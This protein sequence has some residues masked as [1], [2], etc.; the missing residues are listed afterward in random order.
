MRAI[1]GAIAVLVSLPA[2]AADV[3]GWFAEQQKAGAQAAATVPQDVCPRVI[4]SAALDPAVPV[5]YQAALCYLQGNPPDLVAARAWLARSAELNY[6][7]AHRMLRALKAVE[8]AV[9]SAQPHCHD[10]GA[11]Q[12]I[13]HGGAR[14]QPLVAAPAN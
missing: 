2:P 3:G 1:A 5:A 7:P 14:G 6:L 10:L 13:C 12:Q 11:G 4:A 8:A 9:H